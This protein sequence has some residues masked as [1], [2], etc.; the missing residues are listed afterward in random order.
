MLVENKTIMNDADI[1]RQFNY[2]KTK[3]MIKFAPG[4]MGLWLVS[5]VVSCN[6]ADVPAGQPA[7]AIIAAPSAADLQKAIDRAAKFLLSSQNSNGWWSTSEQPAVTAL[8][9]TALNFEPSGQ[10]LRH[11]SSELARAYDFI[12]TSAKPD[13]SIQRAGLANYNTAL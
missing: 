8:V 12:L 1:L 7:A 4:L 5:M 13:G 11:R 10:F 2:M 3:T 6:A 9:L